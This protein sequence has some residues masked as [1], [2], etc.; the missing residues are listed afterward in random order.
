[1]S[2]GRC[3]ASREN[4]ILIRATYNN[5]HLFLAKALLLTRRTVKHWLTRIV[6][7]FSLYLYD[8]LRFVAR[9]AHH[10]SPNFNLSLYL[11]VIAGWRKGHLE[12][13]L[14]FAV[15]VFGCSSRGIK[16]DF[17]ATSTFDNVEVLV[18]CK[19]FT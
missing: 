1:M 8:V 19:H 11:C 13:R 7:G 6:R 3:G 5:Q 15:A 12:G 18:Y 9:F 16:A 10:T 14:I 2:F 17:C 4:V